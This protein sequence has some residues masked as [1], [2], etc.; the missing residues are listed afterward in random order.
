[1]ELRSGLRYLFPQDKGL[2]PTLL[3]I[4]PL[5]VDVF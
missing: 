3:T 2:T 1:M 5:I 4:K